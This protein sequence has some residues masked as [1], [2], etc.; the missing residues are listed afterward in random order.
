MAN[1]QNLKRSTPKEARENGRKGGLASVEARRERKRMSE[2][3]ADFLAKEHDLVIGGEKK[4]IAGHQMLAQ[5]MSKILARGDSASVSLIKEIREATEGSKSTI[6]NPDGS[7]LIPQK[8]IFEI[9]DQQNGSENTDS[10]SVSGS[11]D[12]GEV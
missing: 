5:V 4:K 6:S 10:K 12:P 1:A 2:M 8:V 3:Y 11:T 9:V 7:P